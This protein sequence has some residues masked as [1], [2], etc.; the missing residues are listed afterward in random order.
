MF[1]SERENQIVLDNLKIVPKVIGKTI[2]CVNSNPFMKYD[3]LLQHGRLALC[4]AAIS[5]DPGRPF[6]PYARACVRYAMINYAKMHAS[7]PAEQRPL[8]LDAVIDTDGDLQT[9][10]L[11]VTSDRKQAEAFAEVECM[12]LLTRLMN[13]YQGITKNGVIVIALR[14]LGHTDSNIAKIFGREPNVL[15]AWVA[16]ARQRLRKSQMV[17]DFFESY[18]NEM[19]DEAC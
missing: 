4:I 10:L 13:E 11:D 15:R 12:D 18:R 6:E 14:Y 17:F 9:N 1:L 19:R 2:N 8:S 16:R 7:M 5:A 3:D